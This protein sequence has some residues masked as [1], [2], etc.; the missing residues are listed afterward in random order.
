MPRTTGSHP[1]DIR[2][3]LMKDIVEYIK[4]KLDVTEASVSAKTLKVQ[5]LL[6]LPFTL[7]AIFGLVVGNVTLINAQEYALA[8]VFNIIG[9]CIIVPAIAYIHKL[10]SAFFDPSDEEADAG[11]TPGLT[12]VAEKVEA[13]VVTVSNAPERELVAA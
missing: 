11:T 12:L 9:A 4:F 6:V 3:N 13:S 7:F 2:K 5:R 8:V 10:V 1:L